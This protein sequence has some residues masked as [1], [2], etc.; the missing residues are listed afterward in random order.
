[1]DMRP[2]MRKAS[3]WFRSMSN[4]TSSRITTGM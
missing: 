2:L 3:S 1:M 4:S